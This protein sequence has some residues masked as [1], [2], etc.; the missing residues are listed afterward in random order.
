MTRGQALQ[1]L[2]LDAQADHETIRR[3]Y[4]RL[5][6]KLHPDLFQDPR[7]KAEANGAF[8]RVRDAYEFFKTNRSLFRGAAEGRRRAVVE[9]HDEWH[10]EMEGLLKRRRREQAARGGQSWAQSAS[11][12]WERLGEAQI[13]TLTTILLCAIILVPP[14]MV[15]GAAYL[16]VFVRSLSIGDAVF[17]VAFIALCRSLARDIRAKR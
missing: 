9:E 17:G 11:D 14:L 5:C 16:R 6:L 2:G 10:R 13:R 8:L 12:W 15:L 7:E 3:R 1:T 4:R